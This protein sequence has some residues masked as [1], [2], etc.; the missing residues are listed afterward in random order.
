MEYDSKADTLEHMKMV[1]FDMHRVICE[2]I[3]RIEI[4]D[5]G[6]LQPE[7]KS[8]F[9]EYT[10]RLKGVTFGSPEYRQFLNE[11][12]PALDHH[13]ATNRHHPEFFPDGIRG[14]NLLDMIEMICDWHASSKRHADGDPLKS[15]EINQKRFG[16]SD[17]M[18]QVFINTMRWVSGSETL[19][20]DNRAS[21]I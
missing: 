1:A 8:I 18:K 21:K 4:H 3:H 17:E 9:D 5:K 7:E 11:M 12:K 19:K 15:I 2:I 10:P 20:Y 16:Y 13:Y 6:K 14:M